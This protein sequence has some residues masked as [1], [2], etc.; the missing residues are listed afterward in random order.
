[1]TD[2]YVIYHTL[3]KYNK[4]PFVINYFT[5]N[6]ME[7]QRN[8]YP[9]YVYLDNTEKLNY[10]KLK[11]KGYTSNDFLNSLRCNIP[12]L[13]Y[14]NKDDNVLVYMSGHGCEG[15]FKFFDKEWLTK[16]DLMYNIRKLCQ[17]ANKVLLIID[18]CSAESMVERDIDNL[19]V[20]STSTYNEASLSYGSNESLGVTTVD[21]FA[22]YF[23]K[24]VNT[25]NVKD[26]SLNDFFSLV[27]EYDIKSTMTYSD[28]KEFNFKDF[29]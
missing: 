10:T 9:S 1:M 21:S 28:K 7:D 26:L 25:E 4:N 15:V 24:V 29:F 16:E 12:E 23:Y 20:V 18:T 13:K 6:I 5:E 19:Y 8:I 27:K 14:V 22:Y 17:R 3:L 11:S 2:I